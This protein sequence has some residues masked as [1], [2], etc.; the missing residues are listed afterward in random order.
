MHGEGQLKADGW[1]SLR[2][3]NVTSNTARGGIRYVPYI[4]TEQGVAMLSSVVASQCAPS[5]PTGCAAELDV[6]HGTTL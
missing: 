1:E 6:G 5:C 4:F 3:Q 2:S